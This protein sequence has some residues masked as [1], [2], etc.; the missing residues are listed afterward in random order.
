MR[1]KLILLIFFTGASFLLK[2]QQISYTY[3]NPKDSSAN[4]F[5][6][7][8][9]PSDTLGLLLLLPGFGEDPNHV[10]TESD[11][12]EK[13][14]ARGLTTVIASLPEGWK[15]FY[16]DSS[17]QAA[18]D[19]LIPL[20]LEKYHLKGKK[21]FLGGF[22]LGG[23]GVVK[24]AERAAKSA[25]LTKPSAIFSIDPPLD[26][27]RMYYS[28]IKKSQLIPGSDT[29]KNFTNFFLDI[30]QK[31]FHGSPSSNPSAYT[32]I[33]PYSFTHPAFNTPSLSKLPI[34]LI[35]EPDIDHAM[36]NSDWGYFDLNV[37][38]CSSLIG[39]LNMV[40]NKDA[41][42]ITTSNRGYRKDTK[43]KNPHSWSIADAA[44]VLDWLLLH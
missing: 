40:G 8:R 35:C 28:L 19:H 21:F 18:L 17:S 39:C 33:S 1:N 16:P 30:I 24:Y 23:S 31:K 4:F 42:L 34:M 11:L 26:F 12:P 29:T 37:V 14:A 5:I 43:I 9:N 10:L 6:T 38:D 2:S 22:S 44:K 15:T 20:L 27:E 3:L 41:I 36:K 25:I 13:A 7:Y 32:T